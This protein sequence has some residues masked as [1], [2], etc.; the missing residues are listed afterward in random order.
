MTKTKKIISILLCFALAVGCLA[1]TGCQ[2]DDSDTKSTTE[3][4]TESSVS[5]AKDEPNMKGKQLSMPEKGEQIAIIH[6]NMGDIKMKFFPEVAP[7]AVENFIGLAKDKKYDNTIFHRIINDFM[8]QGGDYENGDGTGGTSYFG[9]AFEDEFS[10][11][12][13]NLRGS[14][15][16]A[17][18]GANTN[19]SQFFINQ[20]K[21]SSE[22]YDW[23]Q[24][25]KTADQYYEQIESAAQSDEQM[26]QRYYSQYYTGLIDADKM[27]D[28]IKKE[29]EENGGNYFLDGA[30][31]K[32]GRG[33]T[34]FA[35]V[36]EGMDVVDKIAA[37][38]VDENNK[39]LSDVTVKS[40]EI[41]TY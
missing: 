12:I 29:Y 8:I 25:Q 36:F 32:I 1:F 31:S 13:V 37:V 14:V 26:K 40:V 33:H 28:D 9:Q 11:Q 15:A 24:V 22:G 6:T 23:E 5:T 16:M 3:S 27:S 7:K 20:A 17:N 35:Q 39:P 2:N 10:S 21:P 19:G 38:K 34:V 41:T 18:S 4:K 30:F